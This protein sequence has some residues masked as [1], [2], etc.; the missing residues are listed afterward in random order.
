MRRARPRD[1]LDVATGSGD[2]AFAL[3][4]R[5][6][7]GTRIVG[8]DFCSP[9]L[10][11]ARAKKPQG[12]TPG[13]CV[14]FALGDALNLPFSEGEFDSVTIAFGLRNMADRARCLSEIRRVLR[15]A[16]SLFILEFSQP[17]NWLRPIYFFLL[18]HV[19]PRVAALLTGDRAAYDYLGDSIAAFPGPE[20]LCRE[21]RA[22]G[23]AQVHAAS[24]SLGIVAL[25]E[26]RR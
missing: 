1:V 15:P 13:G 18:S 8:M 5:L 20:G 23:F 14:E 4:R 3:A 26:A 12:A 25:H 7:A 19:V 22:A 24:M 16:G 9:M 6:P 2:V 17:K 21:V 11:E 10:D